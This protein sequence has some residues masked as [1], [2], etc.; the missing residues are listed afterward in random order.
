TFL[1]PQSL[2]VHYDMIETPAAAPFCSLTWS[3]DG[4]SLA[5]PSREKADDPVGIFLLD[6][7]TRELRRLTT[8]PPGSR[9]ALLPAFSPDG[10]TIAFL[11]GG[12]VSGDGDIWLVSVPGGEPRPLTRDKRSDG[13]PAW[14]AD[15]QS[16]VVSSHRGVVPRLRRIAAAS[17][18][19]EA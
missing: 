18:E 2:P 6:V 10:R 11:R 1:C 3:P 8:P 5:F 17:G 4:K 15:G 7:E 13:G 19:P 14:T 9:G 12:G 16:I